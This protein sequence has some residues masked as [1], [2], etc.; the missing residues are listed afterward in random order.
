MEI[1]ISNAPTR[2]LATPFEGLFGR[3]PGGG[4][5]GGPPKPP[6]GGG[7]GGGGGGIVKKETITESDNR[8]HLIQNDREM[9][10]SVS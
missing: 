8:R 7:G 3:P 6:G 10:T 9:V 1:S 5:G 2:S 4:G